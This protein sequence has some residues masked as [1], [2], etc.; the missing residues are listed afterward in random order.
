ME[1]ISEMLKLKTPAEFN[2]FFVEFQPFNC[3]IP[4]DFFGNGHQ[5]K[6][7]LELGG[8]R[9][10]PVE[11]ICPDI[12]PE[13]F[14]SSKDFIKELKMSSFN[15]MMINFTFLEGFDQLKVLSIWHC[16]NFH[17]TSLPS[18]KMLIELRISYCKGL[19]EWMH[20][21]SLT[22]GLEIIGLP[23]NGLTDN[24]ADRL[25]QWIVNGPSKITLSRVDL[26][27]NALTRIPHHIQSAN[28]IRW[29]NM[30]NQEETSKIFY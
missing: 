13:A 5:I 15:M 29:I 21:P 18:L 12:H 8:S 2:L 11:E 28:K 26:G 20:F 19:N 7:R 4:K 16:V 1:Q 17:L 22:N 30:D 23:G 24:S 27:S 25:F 6:G 3:F 10:F 14:R 9:N